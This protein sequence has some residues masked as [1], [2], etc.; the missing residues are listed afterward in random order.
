[1]RATWKLVKA[2]S[3][4]SS[5]ISTTKTENDITSYKPRLP[6]LWYILCTT[7]L[8]QR[9]HVPHRNHP[10]KKE[11]L[12]ESTGG[13]NTLVPGTWY[14]LCWSAAFIRGFVFRAAVKKKSTLSEPVLG[15]EAEPWVQA[16]NGRV[17]KKKLILPKKEATPPAKPAT[18]SRL[19]L[20]PLCI[21]NGSA[22]RHGHV[23]HIISERYCRSQADDHG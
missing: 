2:V 13:G 10:T 3:C 6:I 8:L 18:C 1:M 17:Q 22:D 5:T 14:I 20:V 21:R 11:Q 7:I 12:P 9:L 16:A 15:E 19:L 4:V 23:A